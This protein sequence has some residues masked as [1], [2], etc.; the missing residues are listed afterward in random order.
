VVNVLFAWRWLPESRIVDRGSTTASGRF[1]P[2]PQPRPVLHALWDVIWHPGRPVAYVI[3]I[4]VIA[5][6]AYNSTPPIFSLY[7]AWRFGITVQNIGWFFVI[8]GAVGVVMRAFV[9]GPINDRLGEVRT[10]WLGAVL[11]ALGYGL[12]PLARSVPMFL[13]FQVLLPLGTA[14][15]FPANSALV[16][17]R[18]ERHEYGLMMGVQQALRG[19]A[20]VIAPIWAG[21][22]YERLGPQVPF[23]A[24]SVIITLALVLATRVRIEEPVTATA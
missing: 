1:V 16:S 9:V 22:A 4:Y 13:T 18:A 21:V 3:W 6:L 15:F 11:Y 7:L 12:L 2:P 24:C 14:L 5:M 19:V 8:F 20:S 10:M 23:F 17:H